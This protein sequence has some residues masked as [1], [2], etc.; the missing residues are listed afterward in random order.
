MIG[1][2]SYKSA[3]LLALIL[4]VLIIGSLAFQSHPK[5]HTFSHEAKNE[6]QNVNE[7]EPKEEI[8]RAVSINEQEVLETVNKLKSEKLAK[9]KQEQAKQQALLKEAQLLQKR[10]VAEQQRLNKLKQEAI[11]IAKE[12]ERKLI[13][14][15]KNLQILAKQKITEE[16]R[17]K[18]LKAQQL[19]ETKKL[20]DLNRKKVEAEA[21]AKEEQ[22]KLKAQ[23]EAEIARLEAERKSRIQAQV[24]K[25][26][27]LIIS[28]IG[29]QWIVPEYADNNLSSQ[30][31]IQL[32][33]TGDVLA[34]VLTRSSGDAV[35]D[36]SA[37]S[38]IYKASPLPVP[39]NEEA[40]KVFKN[41]SLT[42][43]PESA[44]G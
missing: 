2:K 12:R 34:V 4:H 25:Y 29:R 40:F 32:A 10:R 39:N 3:F 42:V 16:K 43:R 11:K 23:K 27:S 22:A 6:L 35:L 8:V 37:E 31:R 15:K 26:K 1:Q 13:Q 19:Q 14:E 30:F 38:A 7:N 44:R 21:K 36:R 9:Q 18:D 20:A 28:A 17:L 5:K 41:I 24:N 33:P